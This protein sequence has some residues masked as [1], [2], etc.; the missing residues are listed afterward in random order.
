MHTESIVLHTGKVM[1][2]LSFGNCYH[3]LKDH[4]IF[5]ASQSLDKNPYAQAIYWTTK[6]QAF[7][8]Q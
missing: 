4:I 6:Q 7:K 3:S 2:V 5:S 1:G 8:Q